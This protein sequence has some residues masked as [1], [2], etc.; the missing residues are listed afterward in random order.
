MNKMSIAFRFGFAGLLHDIGKFSQ[1][2]QV[3]ISHETREPQERYWH[4]RDKDNP[5][6]YSH[7]LHTRQFFDE[8]RLRFP[9]DDPA[10]PS[11]N[12][13]TLAS[14][15]HNP[16]SSEQWIIAVADRL[17][18]GFDRTECEEE[19]TG[20][21]AYRTTYLRPLFESIRIS[22]GDSQETRVSDPEY[23]YGLTILDAQ[24]KQTFPRKKEQIHP[25][26]GRDLPFDILWDQFTKEAK[27]LAVLDHPSEWDRHMAWMSLLEQYTWCIPSSVKD[28]PDISLYDHLVTTAGIAAVL[29]RFH[30]EQKA[31]NELDIKDNEKKKFRMIA[32]D[33]SGIQGFIFGQ[34]AEPPKRAAVR[35]RARSFLV[36]SISQATALHIIHALNLPP[37]VIFREAAGQFLILAPNLEQTRVLV[38]EIRREL[39][40]YLIRRYGGELTLNLSDEVEACGGDFQVELFERR[41]LQA[42]NHALEKAKTAKLSFALR[43]SGKAWNPQAFV[44]NFYPRGPELEEMEPS[45]LDA[46]S[47]LNREIETIGRYLP[48]TESLVWRTERGDADRLVEL[49]FNMTVELCGDTWIKVRD[50]FLV[51]RL[52]YSDKGTPWTVR[53]VANYIP[54]FEKDDLEDGQCRFCRE[55]YAEQYPEKKCDVGDD[56]GE[57]RIHPGMPRTFECLGK[58]SLEK[59]DDGKPRGRELIGILKADVDNLGLIFGLGLGKRASVSRYASLSR[60]LHQF[61]VGHL[62]DLIRNKF[63][64]I[65]TVYAGGDDLFLV[66]PWHTMIEFA[67]QMYQDFREYTCQNPAITISA[68]LYFCNSGYPIRRAATAAHEALEEAKDTGRNRITLFNTPIPWDELSQLNKWKD[69]FDSALRDPESKVRTSFLHRL[70][71]YREMCL[72]AEKGVLRGLLYH[73]HMQ[74]DIARNIRRV[75]DGK[76]VNESEIRELRKL[77]ADPDLLK[78]IHIP[79]YEVLY[80]HRGGHRHDAV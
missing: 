14:R 1:R 32:G 28:L 71:T 8:V 58:L 12:T 21:G 62:Q 7:A 18:A 66:G 57:N 61:F 70:L 53:H 17:S 54:K 59:E 26:E 30:E 4:T 5:W 42:S 80:R 75:K 11:Q 10:S 74:Y 50:A 38:E 43:D 51:E 13:A 3:E 24:N 16:S 64:W 20:K 31:W 44:V 72:E 39:D 47:S 65:Y 36:G 63:P 79:I 29:A 76:V 46:S 68:G 33:V 9:W 69:F 23:R 15:H 56:S 41:I 37:S 35:L 77:A 40:Q 60:L 49:P 22:D 55:M 48:G 6:S 27:E 34:E 78:K 45:E 67:Q 19:S 25:P 52:R 73:S 2:A